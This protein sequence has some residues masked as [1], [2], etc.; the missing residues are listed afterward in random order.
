MPGCATTLPAVGGELPTGRLETLGQEG[1][2]ET[3]ADA[4]QRK[5]IVSRSADGRQ[6]RARSPTAAQRLLQAVLLDAL[7]R[8]RSS[9]RRWTATSASSSRRLRRRRCVSR[10]SAELLE[11][12]PDGLASRSSEA[13]RRMSAAAPAAPASEVA[14]SS[15][16]ILPCT[17]AEA[18]HRRRASSSATSMSECCRMAAVGRAA[19]SASKCPPSC[20]FRAATPRAACVFFAFHALWARSR[21]IP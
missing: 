7:W 6:Y 18:A 3:I 19:A 9:A 14:T 13:G 16:L 4:V 12:S 21:P 1:W 10:Q 5:K 11:A 2:T 15:G 20:A 8:A 17:Y